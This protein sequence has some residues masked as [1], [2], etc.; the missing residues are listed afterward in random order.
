MAAFT[1]TPLYLEVRRPTR[2]ARVCQ[3]RAVHLDAADTVNII[4]WSWAAFVWT[5]SAIEDTKYN[6]RSHIL[7]RK[8]EL[9]SDIRDSK[10]E[11]KSDLRRHTAELGC[12]IRENKYGLQK[13]FKDRSAALLKEQRDGLESLQ[14]AQRKGLASLRDAQ[15]HGL[16]SLQKEEREELASL[17]ADV[18]GQLASLQGT[19]G[20]IVEDLALLRQ[21][22]T[23]ARVAENVTITFASTPEVLFVRVPLVVGSP[24]SDAFEYARQLVP[25][26]TGPF[27]LFSPGSGVHHRLDDEH[28]FAV[29]DLEQ[30]LIVLLDHQD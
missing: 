8:Y 18:G 23:R 11:L 21:E 27:H 29:P 13:E 5:L 26:T 20:S 10:Y 4:I 28:L 19:V 7:D 9:G 12:D 14:E 15:H 3:L 22:V 16:E 6:L 25:Q 30:G 2:G 24:V 17:R 1:S